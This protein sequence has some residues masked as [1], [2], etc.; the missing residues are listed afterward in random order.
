MKSFVFLSLVLFSLQTCSK[1]QVP[2]SLAPIPGPFLYTNGPNTGGALAFGCVFTYS[3]GTTSPFATYTDASGTT[4]N[5]N[6]VVLNA[7]GYAAIWFQS[8]I[9]YTIKVASSGGINCA[10]GTTQY[11]VN[12]VNT[13]LLNL[14][15]TWQQPQIFDDPIQILA[16]DLQIVFGSPSGAQTTLDIPPTAGNYIL[17]GPPLT[18]NDTL[19]S[20]N[21][22]QTVQNKNL[23]TRTQI[24]GCGITNGPGTYI[25]VPNNA[26]TATLLNGLAVLTGAPSTAT[27][28]PL[29]TAGGVVGI[30]TAGAGIT[31]NATIQQSGTA[32]CIFDGATTSGDYVI[33]SAITA[34][35]CHDSGAFPISGAVG[36]VTSTNAGAGSYQ[37]LLNQQ[38]ALPLAYAD[39]TTTVGSGTLGVTLKSYSIPAGSMNQVGKAFRA[40]AQIQVV[41]NGSSNQIVDWATNSGGDGVVSTSSASAVINT[42]LEIICTVTTAGSSGALSCMF[43]TET[44]S[45]TISYTQWTP[46]VDLTAAVKIG[47]DC[48]FSA[49]SGNVCSQYQLVVQPLN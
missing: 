42:N 14:S 45:G 30:V 17:H 39:G 49:N 34:G 27:A 15:N 20:Q 13:S 32:N 28:A 8:G 33:A 7:G 4:M 29:S 48:R 35:N 2:V 24:N 21:A 19:L 37:I 36:S 5:P 40:A 25:C 46:S 12:N 38:N 1:A 18:G 6:P 9:E 31:G 22:I 23:T 10:S 47:N 16:P 44:S 43:M 3:T 11:T 41:P 26:S